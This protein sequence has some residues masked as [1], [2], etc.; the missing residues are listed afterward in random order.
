MYN[1]YA[2]ENE[3][4][5]VSAPVYFNQIEE[6]NIG[7]HQPRKDQCWCA[8]YSPNDADDTEAEAYRIHCLRKAA[9]RQA[10]DEDKEEADQKPDEVMTACFDLE[11]VLYSPYLSSKQIFYKRKLATFNFTVCISKKKKST[12]SN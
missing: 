7:F 11:A 8:R 1:D 2:A 12:F 10:K 3:L 4:R 9:A 5:I 6:M